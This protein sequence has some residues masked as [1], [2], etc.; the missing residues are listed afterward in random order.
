MAKRRKPNRNPDHGKGLLKRLAERPVILR[1]RMDQ[2][3]EVYHLMNFEITWD[4]MPDPARDAL[5][6]A[7][8]D[9]MEK[10]FVLLQKKPQSVVSE[11]RELAARH[12]AVHCFTNWLISALRDGTKADQDEALSLC[13]Q[14]FRDHPGYFFART[15]LA[16]MWLDQV[17]VDKAAA[18]LFVPGHTIS[19]LYPDRKV[20]HISEIRHWA[21]LSARAKIMLGEP[22]I[23]KSY[24]DMLEELEPD[25]PAVQDLN[26]MLDGEKSDIIRMLA[27]LRK[28]AVKSQERAEK[29]KE[30]PKSKEPPK[31][32]AKPASKPPTKSAAHPDQ[33][34]LFE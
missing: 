3:P 31:T 28:F 25:S 2:P 14:M 19:S 33:L 5:P 16:D 12:P 1:T 10:I 24:R 6:K 29:R 17:D 20:F 34:D 22:E 9:R 30:R 18:L 27:N 7:T 4:V 21:Y 13:E 8:R 32:P 15:T 11:L 26:D 23:A